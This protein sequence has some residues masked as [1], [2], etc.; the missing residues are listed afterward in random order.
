MCHET[1]QTADGTS[2]PISGIGLVRYSLFITLS[3]VLHVPS[4]LI[5][6][7]SVSS[8]VNQFNYTIFFDRNV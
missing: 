7:L 1:L 4:F 2:Q 5:N 3:L 8:V 6:L